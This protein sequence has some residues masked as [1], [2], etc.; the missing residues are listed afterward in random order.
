[1]P[2]ILDA[3]HV[4]ASSVGEQYQQVLATTLGQ[5]YRRKLLIM[6]IIAIAL[7]LGIA[8]LH[9]M[10]KRYTAEA[11]IRGGFVAPHAVATDQVSSGGP[12][13]AFDAS[14]VVETRARLFQ[15]HQLA[16][17]V[18]EDLGL[19]RLRPVVSQ[20]KFS[21]WLHEKVYGDA[22][23]NAPEYQ[24]DMAAMKLSRG[25]L[26]KTEPRVYL[27]TLSYTAADPELAALITN[28]FV[29]EFLRATALQTLSEQ[30]DS[31]QAT[32][33]QQL[34]TFGDKHP[35]VIEARV[36]LA[37][38]DS[39]F[40]AELGKST[41]EILNGAGENIAFAQANVVPSSPKPLLV[42]GLAFLVGLLASIGLAIWLGPRSRAGHSAPS[43]LRERGAPHLETQL[44]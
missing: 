9:V 33:S 43:Q 32:L 22:T 1:M 34:A 21:S 25:L 42:I 13:L 27:I 44:P 2:S 10:P 6:A 38:A 14:L 31:A 39:L 8:A 3:V 35:K 26:V 23:T 17:Q 12:V 41:E 5:L 24:E 16:R 4:E 18:V 29:V 7:A 11:Y 15:S 19:E 30:R 20:G 36:R 28:T 40:K 37:T